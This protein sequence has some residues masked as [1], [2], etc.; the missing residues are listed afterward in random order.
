MTLKVKPEI[1]VDIP[2]S[3]LELDLPEKMEAAATTAAELAEHGL[4]LE[5]TKEDQENAAKLV[6]AYAEDPEGTSKKVTL[7]KAATLTPASLI[8]TDKIL[9]E[10]G[11]SVVENSLHIRHMVTNK[12]VL[13][14]ENPDPRI[15]MRAL[16]LLGKI[17]DVGLFSEKSEVTITHQSTDDLREKL[18]GKLEKL[19]A[20]EVVEEAVVVDVDEELG[21]EDYDD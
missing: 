17:S 14:S 16:E 19:V 5:V 10:F 13:E 1:A 9:K 20:G 7:K 18:K 12:L 4:D 3:D 2:E 6:A 8:M 21:I 11:Q 15:R